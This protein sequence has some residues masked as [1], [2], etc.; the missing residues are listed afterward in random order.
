MIKAKTSKHYLI[1]NIESLVSQSILKV[2]NDKKI[3]LKVFN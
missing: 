1:K 2:I 3:N